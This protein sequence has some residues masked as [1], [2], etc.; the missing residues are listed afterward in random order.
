MKRT[1]ARAITTRYK[2]YAF[3][4]RLEARWAVF[5]DHLGIR[6]DYEPEGFELGNG[7]R[8]L[9]DFWL[10]DWGMWV[11]VKPGE[12]D[13]AACEKAW[14]LVAKGDS[15]LLLVHGMPDAG[16]TIFATFTKEGRI[17]PHKFPAAVVWSAKTKHR[18]YV[19][20]DQLAEMAVTP[21]QQL[22]FDQVAG[23]TMYPLKVKD[24][25]RLKTLNEDP[26]ASA[27]E[28]A[29]AARFEF[30]EKGGL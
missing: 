13:H 27:L 18:L 3:R 16:A 23:P 5:F 7:L 1:S 28:A 9:P 25:E 4:S 8:Y 29:R 11:E 30:G 19:L 20:H 21:R 2:G 10:P 6:W 24:G 12:P 26:G 14:R 22:C 15:P 17:K